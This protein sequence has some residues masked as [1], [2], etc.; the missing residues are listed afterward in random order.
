M[1]VDNTGAKTILYVHNI[2]GMGGASHSLMLMARRI[3]DHGWKP[4]VAGQQD[5]EGVWEQC[6]KAGIPYYP[7]YLSDWSRSGMTWHDLLYLPSKLNT[8]R[9]LVRI[10][11]EE[12]VSLVHTNLQSC[13]EGAFAAR[14]AGLPHI[15]H[16]REQ[17]NPTVRKYWGGVRGGV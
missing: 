4:I 8:I 15:F 13:L 9:K 16:V 6:E 2:A 3:R 12:D 10:C 11:R 5:H 1:K 7:L 14:I 17:I